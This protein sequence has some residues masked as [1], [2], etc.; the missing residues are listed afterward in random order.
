MP[1][2]EAGG[3]RRPARSSDKEQDD[4]DKLEKGGLRALLLSLTGDR[5]VR[6]SQ[7]A[8]GGAGRPAPV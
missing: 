4:V 7:G 3:W 1:E 2:R 5:E 6:L 8:A